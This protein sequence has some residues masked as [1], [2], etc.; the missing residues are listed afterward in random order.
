MAPHHLTPAPGAAAALVVSMR[1]T[2][3]SLALQEFTAVWA[4]ASTPYAHPLLHFLH[5]R[6]A[7]KATATAKAKVQNGR[8][9]PHG[10]AR[11]QQIPYNK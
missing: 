8:L 1:L 11:A 7:P 10:A 5:S 6:S 3:S 4:R 2:D 9:R